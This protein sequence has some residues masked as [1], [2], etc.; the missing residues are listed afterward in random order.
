MD[1]SE[2]LFTQLFRC[3]WLGLDRYYILKPLD[4]IWSL[5][6]TMHNGVISSVIFI[7]HINDI[8]KLVSVCLM[9]AQTSI[10]LTGKKKHAIQICNL[11]SGCAILSNMSNWKCN[12]PF[13]PSNKDIWGIKF[14]PYSSLHLSTFG[15]HS[16]TKVNLSCIYWS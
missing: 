1:E 3:S 16:I 9:F 14:Y 11:D 13:P 15:F 12:P 5:V 6:C 2:V 10:I 7:G 8:L 4:E